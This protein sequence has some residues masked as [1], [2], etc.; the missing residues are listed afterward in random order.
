M[1]ERL[2]DHDRSMVM[3]ELLRSKVIAVAQHHELLEV[4]HVADITTRTSRDTVPKDAESGVRQLRRGGGA[5]KAIR[6][7]TPPSDDLPIRT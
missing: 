2:T 3:A 6:E 4:P 7:N 1:V 5:S